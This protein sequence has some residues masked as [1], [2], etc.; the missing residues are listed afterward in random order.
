MCIKSP[1][2]E[3]A[4]DFGT[5]ELPA[6]DEKSSLPPEYSGFTLCIDVRNMN[7]LEEGGYKLIIEINGER[8]EDKE[9][10]VF[11]GE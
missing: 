7:V 10:P 9:I 5:A 8:L 3:M 2:G 6:S 11:K 4:I 1:S